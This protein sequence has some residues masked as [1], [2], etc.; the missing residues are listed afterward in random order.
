MSINKIFIIIPSYNEE[1]H[2]GIVLKKALSSKLPVILVDDGSTDSTCK[3]AGKIAIRTIRHN[4][5]IGKGA[6]LKTG[7]EAAFS[8]G[9]EAVILMDSDGQHKIED[10]NNFLKA[11]EDGNDV[12]L[13]SR[14]LSYGVPFVRYIGNKFASLFISFLFGIYVSDILCG[15]RAFT[16][17]AYKKIAWE[18]T[19][20][21]VETE[22]VIN[23]AKAKLKYCEVS[24]ETVYL[25]SYKGVTI[26]D[27][28]GILGS[29]L[30]WR[31]TK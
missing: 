17:K 10:L 15:Y 26:L 13:G 16:K 30:K 1:R 14:N 12:V 20:Y 23:I 28:F 18:S 4:T 11:L 2:I 21:G 29:A 24:V 27:A 5:N 31:L 25:D 7:C 3:I 22:M 6:A 9:A 8:L 19:G